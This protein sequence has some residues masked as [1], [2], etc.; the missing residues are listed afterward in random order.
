VHRLLVTANI[1]PGS[2]ILV[3]LMKEALRSSEMAVLTRP[4]LRYTPEDGIFHSHPRE[5]LKFF[6]ALTG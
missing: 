5:K 1:V 6:I 2:S 3:T 4:T